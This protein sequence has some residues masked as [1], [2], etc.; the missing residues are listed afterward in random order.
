MKSGSIIVSLVLGITLSPAAGLTQESPKP[1]T[2]AT[3]ESKTKAAAPIRKPAPKK[4]KADPLAPDPKTGL[5][6]LIAA[7]VKA[8]RMERAE[9]PKK[10]KA[11][12]AGGFVDINSASKE[13]LK[14]L[15]GVTDEL[16]AKI[17]AGR[18]YPT[19][20]RLIT[21]DVMPMSVYEPNKA[22]II[23]VQKTAK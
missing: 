11:T 19:K 23:A 21:N 3:Q 17:I 22:R 15:K 1:P 18:P 9:A 16:A 13:E 8:K 14:T 6:P 5:N 12:P 20:A 7:Q 2:P 10:T 4:S